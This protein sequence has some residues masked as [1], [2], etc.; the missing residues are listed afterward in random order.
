MR[1]I[2][3][4][5][6]IFN[7]LLGKGQTV[8]KTYKQI[9]IHAKNEILNK[10]WMVDVKSYYQN[11]AIKIT[12]KPKGELEVK[13]FDEKNQL[14]HDIY[15]NTNEIDYD[16]N[17]KFYTIKS[18]DR[19]IDEPILLVLSSIT[20]EILTYIGVIKPAKTPATL[21]MLTY[22]IYIQEKPF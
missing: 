14:I 2:L 22:Y 19:I 16:N 10:N 4:L 8:E 12:M 9:R 3:F 18:L 7:S 17:L 11:G 21:L 13:I 6:L 15:A 5:F 20:P 1:K